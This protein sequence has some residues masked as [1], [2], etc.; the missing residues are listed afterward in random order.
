MPITA[1]AVRRRQES[2]GSTYAPWQARTLPGERECDMGCRRNR[3][4]CVRNRHLWYLDGDVGVRLRSHDAD[5]VAVLDYLQCDSQISGQKRELPRSCLAHV[6]AQSVMLKPQ[7]VCGGNNVP[8]LRSWMVYM[9][10]SMR[11]GSQWR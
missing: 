10:K 8:S 5:I 7:L 4:H 11:R 3:S 1:F 2:T 9:R 6:K